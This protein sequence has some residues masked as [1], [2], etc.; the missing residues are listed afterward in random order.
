MTARA[1][2]ALSHVCFGP[3]QAAFSV[4]ILRR[5]NGRDLAIRG[6]REPGPSAAPDLFR[7]EFAWP[8]E[9][10]EHR[11]FGSSRLLA[12]ALPAPAKTLFSG[13]YKY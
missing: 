11:E 12:Q 7:P 5:T 9:P 4:A 13:S 6:T 8:H 2:D 10:A 3:P 1:G